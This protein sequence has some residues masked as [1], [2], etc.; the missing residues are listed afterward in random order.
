MPTILTTD[1][2][3]PG[4][5]AKIT[6]LARAY[7]HRFPPGAV[8]SFTICRQLFLNRKDLE[9]YRPRDTTTRAEKLERIA[10]QPRVKPTRR[11]QAKGVRIDPSL[12]VTVS[13]AAGLAGCSRSLIGLDCR[14]GRI[15]AVQ[16]DGQW[17][18]LRSAA[19]NRDTVSTGRP[20]THPLP[21]IRA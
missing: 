13:T 2:V 21:A 7:V 10:S 5:A 6:T 9:K 12:Y 3:R 4:T 1:Y 16:I 14:N 19:E 8:R 17:L 15:P 18:V 11:K 20:R